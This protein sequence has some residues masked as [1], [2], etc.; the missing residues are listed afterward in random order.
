MLSKDLKIPRETRASFYYTLNEI[1]NF[2]D[3]YSFLTDVKLLGVKT[4][5]LV[6]NVIHVKRP[7][8]I[9]HQVDCQT[10]THNHSS[11]KFHTCQKT[12]LHSIPSRLSDFNP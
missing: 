4:R 12:G 3:K 8:Y 1:Y 11:F 5:F 7:V 6:L 2:R 9:Q 10:L